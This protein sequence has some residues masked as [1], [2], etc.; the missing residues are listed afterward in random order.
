MVAPESSIPI[1]DSRVDGSGP[2]R[3]T[4]EVV[5]AYLLCKTKA[6]LKLHSHI[7]SPS[8]YETLTSESRDMFGQHAAMKL[9]THDRP[10]RTLRG[11]TLSVPI[12]KRGASIILDATI[13]DEH[14]F[15]EIDGLKR[16]EGP[17]SLGAFYYA[18]VLFC[19]NERI[20]A[21]ERRLLELCGF[22]VG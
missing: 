5:E 19:P 10:G 13:E 12:L 18:P 15:V 6:Y 17:S 4:R 8:D 14:L 3:I 22:L 21:H 7:G 9:A 20:F 11:L 16:R 1:R 2:V